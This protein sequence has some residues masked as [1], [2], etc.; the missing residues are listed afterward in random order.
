MAEAVEKLLADM[1]MAKKLGA[2]ARKFVEENM[3]NEIRAER[4]EKLYMEI[5]KKRLK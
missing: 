4:M 5:I 1:E 2:N 3:S